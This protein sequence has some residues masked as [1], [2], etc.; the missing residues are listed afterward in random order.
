MLF[1][2]AGAFSAEAFVSSVAFDCWRVFILR[3][4]SLG[5]CCSLLLVCTDSAFVLA[6][7]FNFDWRP[8]SVCVV[9]VFICWRVYLPG[10]YLT[11]CFLPA[12]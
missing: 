3:A 11:V 7:L 9:G 4:F 5:A 6:T 2:S 12:H 1:C 10:V 8:F